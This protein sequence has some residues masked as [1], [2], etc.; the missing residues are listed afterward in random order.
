MADGRKRVL[1]VVCSGCGKSMHKKLLYTHKRYECAAVLRREEGIGPEVVPGTI[2]GVGPATY[3]KPWTWADLERAYPKSMWITQ[4]AQ[5]NPLGGVTWNGLHLELVPFEG[6]C[7]MTTGSRMGE[8]PVYSRGV[9]P[10]HWDAYQNSLRSEREVEA[11]VSRVGFGIPV[12]RQVGTLEPQI[13]VDT[14]TGER[15]VNP[16]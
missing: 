8:R 10:P 14:E 11:M 6:G 2:I 16:Y 15:L 5:S 4:P 1:E 12:A 9:P 7:L 13:F 3:K